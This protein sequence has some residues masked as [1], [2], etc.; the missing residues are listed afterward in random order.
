MPPT[1]RRR[2]SRPATPPSSK[3]RSRPD[4]EEHFAYDRRLQDEDRKALRKDSKDDKHKMGQ[5]GP[6]VQVFWARDS[7]RFALVRR[8]ER[9]VA[10]LFVINALSNPR[11]T[12]ERYRYAMPGEANVPQP[13]IEV[14]D[15]A[16]KARVKVKS[17]RFVDQSLQIASAPATAIDRERD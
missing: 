9:K 5:R 13:Q 11:P 15:L 3:P 1:S 7:K 14:F 12:L 4:G 17:E 16:S 6:S 2:V 10:D 8:D